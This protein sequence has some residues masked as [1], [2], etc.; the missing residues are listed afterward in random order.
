MA[1]TYAE[2]ITFHPVF[3][4]AD[5]DQQGLITRMLARHELSF[6]LDLWTTQA[7]A[8][9]ALMLFVCHLLTF[10]KMINPGAS[11]ETGNSQGSAKQTAAVEID[12]TGR[13]AFD[14]LVNGGSFSIATLKDQLMLTPCGRELYNLY[15]QIGPSLLTSMV[16][17]LGI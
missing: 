3:I 5:M 8:E 7:R 1:P 4:T 15:L 11:G 16:V 2:F 13:V 17:G 12:D 10:E 6:P 9:E 14:N